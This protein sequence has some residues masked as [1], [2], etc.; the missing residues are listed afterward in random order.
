MNNLR[1]STITAISKLSDN[2]NLQN[3]YDN[4]NINDVIKY[5]EFKDNEPKGFSKKS[6]KKK[7]KSTIKKTFYNQ[8][9]IHIYHKDKIVNVKIFKNG[10]IQMTGLKYEGQGKEV[11]K[12][13]IEQLIRNNKNIFN[14]DKLEILYYKIVLINSDFDIKYKVNREVLHNEIIKLGLYSS[15]EPCIYPGVNIKYMYNNLYDKCGICKCDCNCNGKGEGLGI[16]DCKRVTIAVF[17]SGK[18]IIT[19]G[20]SKEQLIESYNFITNVLSDRKKFII[21]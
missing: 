5:I 13:V 12:I 16:G 18:I 4:F 21:K 14:K 8:A 3:L 1:I 11:L 7:R 17:N 10:N 2:I 19:G 6:M 20:K 15:Y 9:T